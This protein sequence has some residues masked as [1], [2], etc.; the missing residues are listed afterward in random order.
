MTHIKE[1]QDVQRVEILAYLEA[2]EIQVPIDVVIV[3]N[4]LTEIDFKGWYEQDFNDLET[5]VTEGLRFL[6]Y[7][8]YS[9]ER[10]H[11]DMSYFEKQT[12]SI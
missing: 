12:K 4:E 8:T 1:G 11:I 10:N 5:D 2:A 7:K 9:S 3:N 6:G